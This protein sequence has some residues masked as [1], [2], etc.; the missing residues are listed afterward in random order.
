MFFPVI[1]FFVVVVKRYEIIESK[2][3]AS[4]GKKILLKKHFPKLQNLPNSLD[5][6]KIIIFWKTVYSNIPE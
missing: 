2:I 1:F 4:P 6:S 5:D 3:I